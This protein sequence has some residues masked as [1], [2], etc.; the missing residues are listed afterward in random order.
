MRLQQG[1]LS[2]LETLAGQQP[3]SFNG[4]PMETAST[5]TGTY[6]KNQMDLKEKAKELADKTAKIR[7]LETQ[8]GYETNELGDDYDA[9]K[10]KV[11][12]DLAE[13][14][15]NLGDND[16]SFTIAGTDEAGNVVQIGNK[17][18]TKRLIPIGGPLRPKNEAPPSPEASGRLAMYEGAVNDLEQAL[19][20]LFDKNGSLNRTLLT[21]AA[22]P[23][24]G[25]VGEGR[26]LN[27]LIDNAIE[28]K[29]RA[30]TGAAA[31]NEEVQ[32]ISGRFKPSL[33]D[34]AAT[35]KSRVTRLMD[36]LKKSA[37]TSDPRGTKLRT[38]P[39]K[40]AQGSGDPLG[41]R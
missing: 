26:T 3:G 32:R 16:E 20:M 14:R 9:A 29:L 25:G 17:T 4:L 31:T 23:L 8:F 28:A 34:S 13:K 35:A 36:Y 6:V 18:G 39:T 22:V 11:Q 40:P 37:A 7:S 12:A 10:L 2:K 33:L 38:L 5:L 27:S 24:V 21:K 15:S 41:L 19:P 1:Q 30:E